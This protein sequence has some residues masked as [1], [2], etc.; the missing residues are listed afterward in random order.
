MYN[1]NNIISKMYSTA[2]HQL[3]SEAYL[4]W[5]SWGKCP[6][7]LK[8]FKIVEKNTA[9]NSNIAKF[10]LKIVKFSAKAREASRG[11]EVFIIFPLILI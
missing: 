8:N 7:K 1:N 3:I 2:R 5:S 6:L 4:I 9:K 10:P 11:I